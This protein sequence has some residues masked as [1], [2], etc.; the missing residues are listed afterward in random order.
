MAVP[1]LD[2]ACQNCLLCRMCGTF[3][4]VNFPRVFSQV[5]TSQVC[6][7][8]SAQP[9]YREI[10]HLGSMIWILVLKGLF[11]NCNSPFS[12]KVTQL[13]LCQRW[14]SENFSRFLIVSRVY[15]W[16]G[17]APSYS[18]DLELGQV[19]SVEG[20]SVVASV[21]LRLFIVY[22]KKGFL[23]TSGKKSRSYYK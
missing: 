17:F 11:N 21:P 2:K 1:L 19:C 4:S 9:I 23:K 13:S 5:A 16:N 3:P 8:C 22:S 6:H 18:V 14:K 10:A 20:S 12:E 7:S 15:K